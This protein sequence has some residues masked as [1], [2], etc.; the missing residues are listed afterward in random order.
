MKKL[1]SLWSVL[2][3]LGFAAGLSR[4]GSDQDKNLAEKM[5]EVYDNTPPEYAHGMTRADLAK[6]YREAPGDT[7]VSPSA[8]RPHQTFIYRACGLIKV[9]VDFRPSTAK[10][11]GPADLITNSS[12]PYIDF[13]APT[14]TGSNLD[15]ALTQELRAVQAD[16]EKIKPGVTRAELDKLFERDN[17]PMVEVP[18][19]HLF[20]Q[21]Q[22]FDCRRCGC[23]FI[24]VDFRPSY[25]AKERPTDI[26]TKVS[27][28]Y[29]FA[30][31]IG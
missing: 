3:I 28:P 7:A 27:K 21:H 23:I 1:P 10:P 9:D 22:K 8:F 15:A 11:A 30:G 16:F 17:G 18:D 25:S 13:A 26:I 20:H 2:I 29:I 24:E 4:A 14:N 31:P 12:L 5:V 19:K 6:A